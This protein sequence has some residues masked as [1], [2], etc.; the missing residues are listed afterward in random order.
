MVDL[1][2]NLYVEIWDIYPLRGLKF[3]ITK[4]EV[5]RVKRGMFTF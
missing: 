1:R 5:V 3:E 4:I 2:D